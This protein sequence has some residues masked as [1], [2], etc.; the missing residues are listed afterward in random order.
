MKPNKTALTALSFATGALLFVA[1]ALADMAIGSGYDRLK[2]AIKHTAAQMEQ[3]LDNFTLESMLTLRDN[4]QTLMQSSTVEKIDNGKRASERSHMTQVAG[5]TVSS[6]YSYDDPEVSVW[7]NVLRDDK[8]YYMEY[9]DD[10]GRKNWKTY[11]NPFSEKGAPEVEKIIDALVGNL[12]DY[13]QVE[14]RPEG[15]RMYSGSLSE[16]QVP[17]LL[18]A[19]SSFAMKQFLDSYRTGEVRMPELESDVYIVKIAGKAMENKAGILEYLSGDIAVSGKDK[20]GVQHELSLNVVFKLSDIGSTKVAKPALTG[21]NVEKVSFFGGFSSKY[22]GKYKNDIVIE[23]D[24][25]FVKI[26]ERI[27]EITSVENDRLT[28]KFYEIVKP[29]FEAEYPDKYD[30]TFEYVQNPYQPMSFFTY[31]NAKGEKENG[32]IHLGSYG[33]VYLDVNIEIIGENSTRSL[34]KPY[35]DT[36]FHRVFEE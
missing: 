31:T 11:E 26:G 7:K 8:Y 6:S 27:L 10:Q 35:F 32:Q 12:K 5:N 19:V 14:E 33:K 4:G 30:F 23:K 22:V 16:A 20:S 18:N 21:E 3:G 15:G 28:G 25:Q 9:G 29:G 17:A 34:H 2:N 13:V 24:G 36:E 1:T